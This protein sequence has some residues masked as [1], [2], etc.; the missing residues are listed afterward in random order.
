MTRER[1]ECRQCILTRWRRN[2][3]YRK[4]RGQPALDKPAA[5]PPRTGPRCECRL[6]AEN[7]EIQRG[8]KRA[9]SK[10]PRRRHNDED[11]LDRRALENR[12]KEWGTR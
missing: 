9:A 5:P 8:R 7:R 1:C 2:N 3:R 12:P 4:A 6:C 11:E 10:S